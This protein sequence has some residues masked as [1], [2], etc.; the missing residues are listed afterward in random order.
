M[1]LLSFSWYTQGVGICGKLVTE[2]V[3]KVCGRDSRYIRATLLSR[4]E[5]PKF[6]QKLDFKDLGF[7][8]PS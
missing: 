3:G 2:S 5:M 6:D 8:I 7:M 4:S 1:E